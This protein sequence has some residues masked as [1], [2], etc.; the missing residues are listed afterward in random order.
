MAE[1]R[2]ECLRELET[3]ADFVTGSSEALHPFE[4]GLLDLML[5]SGSFAFYVSSHSYLYSRSLGRLART[6]PVVLYGETFS[7]CLASCVS[8]LVRFR[9]VRSRLVL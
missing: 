4:R 7:V 3:L 2:L 6:G 1:I 8:S 5:V 9:L